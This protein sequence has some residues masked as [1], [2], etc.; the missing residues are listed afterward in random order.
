MRVEHT[1][2]V[3]QFWCPG[4]HSKPERHEYKRPVV[5]VDFVNELQRKVDELSSYVRDAA[6]DESVLLPVATLNA[7]VERAERAEA[8]VRRLLGK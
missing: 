1:G 6:G 2:T 5:P 3:W 4:G 8:E 7:I